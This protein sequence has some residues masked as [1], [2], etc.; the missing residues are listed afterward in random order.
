MSEENKE[1]TFENPEY[2]KTYWHTC[3]H[4]LAQA[5]KR[6]YPEVRI[7]AVEPENAAIL[8]GGGIGTHLQMGIGDGLIPDILDQGI[9]DDIC[10][11]SDEEAINEARALAREEGLLC[12]VSGGTNVVAAR[13]LARQLGS[14]KTVVTLLPDTGERY[15]ST[16]LFED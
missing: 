10:V 11:V 16:E 8:S 4:I 6:L 7:W 13:Q 9:Y 14:G 3:S 1:Y 2:R 5:V 12:G 15:F